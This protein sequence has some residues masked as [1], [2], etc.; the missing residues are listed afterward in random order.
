MKWRV[1]GSRQEDKEHIPPS[2]SRPPWR[3]TTI[4]WPR[5]CHRHLGDIGRDHRTWIPKSAGEAKSG[6]RQ[7]A[8]A[9]AQPTRQ[10]ARG[11]DKQNPNCLGDAGSRPLPSCSSYLLANRPA[12]KPPRLFA[13][14][15]LLLKH[16]YRSV[17]LNLQRFNTYQKRLSRFPKPHGTELENQDPAQAYP[18]SPPVMAPSTTQAPGV[19]W[20]LLPRAF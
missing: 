2:S 8:M 9:D 10:D 17:E 4:T 5:Q 14:V 6:P 13:V 11:A 16:F 1:W 19:T 12:G 20:P 7:P 18:A 3:G 15:S